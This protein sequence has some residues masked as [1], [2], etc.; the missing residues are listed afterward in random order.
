MTAFE[1]SVNGKRLCTA[2]LE[3]GV[4]TTIL[5][6]V[7]S[8]SANPRRTKSAAP[9]EFLSVHA[10]GLD[11]TT[12]EHLTW[13]RRSLK[14][15]DDISIRVV[16]VPRADKPRERRERDLKQ[17]LQTKKNYVRQTAKELGWEV[18]NK[19]KPVRQKVRKRA[20]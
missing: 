13:H 6:W 20:V 4:V 18:V 9:K 17:E 15:G 7:N 1:I 8:P 3:N 10:G 14:V 12:G 19:K 5:N 2:G 16:D 11:T